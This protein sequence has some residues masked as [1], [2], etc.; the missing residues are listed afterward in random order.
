MD[1]ADGSQPLADG[2]PDLGPLSGLS[3]NTSPSPSPLPTPLGDPPTPDAAPPDSE[4]NPNP[5]DHKHHHHHHHHKHGKH[6]RRSSAA[7]PHTI[8]GKRFSI[9]PLMQGSPSIGSLDDFSVEEGDSDSYSSSSTG[10]SEGDE[11][12]ESYAIS[13]GSEDSDDNSVPNKGRHLPFTFDG[14]ASDNL[15]KQVRRKC[16][17]LHVCDAW[18]P[19][20]MAPLVHD[21]CPPL[22]THVRGSRSTSPWTPCHPRPATR[23]MPPPPPTSK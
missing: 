13:T 10:I 5:Q 9:T 4:G 3:I 7:E 1:Q 19:L 12:Q 22:F 11:S 6:R 18:P 21:L 16:E 8:G 2:S 17:A 14:N 23:T 20:Y 15:S